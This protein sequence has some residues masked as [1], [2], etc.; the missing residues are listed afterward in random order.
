MGDPHNPARLGELWN[1]DRLAVMLAELQAVGDLV[2]LSGGWAWHVMAPAVHAEYK[3]AHDHRDADLFVERGNVAAL[4]AR[5]KARGY[6][7]A[8]TRFDRLPRSEGF[9]RYAR[10]AEYGGRPVKMML[11]LFVEAVPSVEVAGFRVL[12]PSVLLAQY[13][14]RHGSDQCFSVR[15]ARWLRERGVNPVGH[16]EMANYRRFVVGRPDSWE[17]RATRKVRRMIR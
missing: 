4:L 16:A 1:E 12:E 15:I 7:R 2:V 6:E 9:S 3:H 13:G 5:L 10:T 8:W 17:N 14:G 11:D